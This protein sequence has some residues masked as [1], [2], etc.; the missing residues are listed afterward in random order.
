MFI[1][2]NT[3]G[4]RFWVCEACHVGMSECQ[5]TV[6][7]VDKGHVQRPGV[8]GIPSVILLSL[9]GSTKPCGC[10]EM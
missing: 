10:D 7:V 5:K 9:K 8:M 4:F 6:D 1:H 3:L 2:D